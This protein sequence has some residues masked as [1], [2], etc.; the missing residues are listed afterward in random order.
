MYPGLMDAI[1]TMRFE[2]EWL[3]DEFVAESKRQAENETAKKHHYVPQM[4]LRRWAVNKLVQPVQV[5]TGDVHPPQPPKMWHTR[6][7]STASRQPTAPWTPRSS[8]SRSICPALRTP[9]R[10]GW[11]RLRS[12]ALEWFR[13]MP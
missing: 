7:T 8:G 2:H 4:Y 13:T 6:R 3:S 11:I 12:G 9:A 5:D 10:T 1:M